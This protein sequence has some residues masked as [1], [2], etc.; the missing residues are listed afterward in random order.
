M[1][2]TKLLKKLET[3]VG[4]DCE[5]SIHL[6]NPLIP[7]SEVGEILLVLKG[8]AE[9]GQTCRCTK[10]LRASDFLENLTTT[11]LEEFVIWTKS[12]FDKALTIT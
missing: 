11:K 1:I 10:L 2:T 4:Y 9:N 6:P 12:K 7:G 5:A 3:D 8:Y